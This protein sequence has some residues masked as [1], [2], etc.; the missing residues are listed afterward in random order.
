MVPVLVAAVLAHLD[1]VPTTPVGSGIASLYRPWKKSRW[2]PNARYPGN[3]TVRP[4]RRDLVCAHRTLPFWTVLKLTR[5]NGE[6]AFCVV[7]DRGP[8]GFCDQGKAGKD[9]RCRRGG[10]WTVATTRRGRRGYYRGMIDA[11]PAVHRMMRSKGWVRVR[12]ERLAGPAV[13][14]RVLRRSVAERR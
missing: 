2:V 10:R 11:T 14:G 13:T 9:P 7:L 4:T 12:V 8:F 6:R 3:W 1:S 5:S